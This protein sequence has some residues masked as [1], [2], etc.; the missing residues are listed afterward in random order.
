MSRHSRRG[1]SGTPEVT[2]DD[3]PQPRPGGGAT[4]APLAAELA[5]LAPAALAA[6]LEAIAA[7]AFVVRAP[8][9][10][11]HANTRGRALLERE[12]ERVLS[13]LRGGAYGVGGACRPPARFPVDDTA[14]HFVAVFADVPGEATHRIAGVAR[15]WG[16]TPRQAA[17]LVL[18]AQGAS[19]RGAAERLVCSEKTIELH[20]SALLAKTRCASRAQ[21]VASFWT[22]QG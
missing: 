3:S 2:S 10:V 4:P 12:R 15:R 7:P 14:D 11:L 5:R 16:L 17:V 9:I 20:V 6:A 19:N 18:V 8:S 13:A 21:L 1:R 22:E